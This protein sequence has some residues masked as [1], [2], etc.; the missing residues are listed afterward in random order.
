MTGIGTDVDDQRPLLPDVLEE[1]QTAINLEN[2]AF[3]YFDLKTA[4]NAA[5]FRNISTPRAANKAC[6]ASARRLVQRLI[7]WRLE[8]HQLLIL[9]GD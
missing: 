3:R 7:L 1:S 8:M 9:V 6:L 2:A 4:K 5:S